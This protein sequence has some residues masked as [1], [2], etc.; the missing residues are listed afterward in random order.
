AI[1]V[2]SLLA[3][4]KQT[5]IL[6]ESENVKTDELSIAARRG[7]N[8]EEGFEERGK[9]VYTLSNQASGNA[10]LD[11]TRSSNGTLTY[12]AAYATGGTGTGG[13]LGNQ[14]AVIITEDEDD[15]L[16]LAV[17]PGSNSIS[18]FKIKE[19]GLQLRSTVSS[20]G[21]RPVSITQHQN[22]VY[23]LNAGGNGNI[24]GFKL[25]NNNKLMPIANS[26][27]ALSSTAAGAAQISFVNEGK[28]LV[29]TEKATNK[30]ITYTV[31]EWGIA[32]A[33]HSITSANPTPFG[34]DAGRNGNVFVSEAAGGAT[35]ASTLSSYRVYY[36]GVITLTDGP[37]SASQSAACWVVITGNGKYAYTTNTASNNISNYNINRQSGSINVNTAIAATTGMG[38]IDAA[39]SNNS[40]YLYVLNATSHTIGA[41]AVANNGNL[42]SVQT[43]TGIPVGATGLAAR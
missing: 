39:L 32:G 6:P 10:V 21:M 12:N 23:V 40:K 31:N 11:F 1:T 36:N 34:F 15:N 29:I 9:H 3:C 18:S 16:L 2:L 30:I 33:M 24:S 43:T 22:I 14:G 41:Y 19:N 7:E 35:G 25:G 26:T 28:V 42:S 17:N 8:G 37:V 38:P 5:S 13:G 4:K 20:G 27:R